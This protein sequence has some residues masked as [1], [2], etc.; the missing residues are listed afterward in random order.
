MVWCV[1]V[2]TTA[3]SGQQSNW[4][5]DLY[6]NTHDPE[7]ALAPFE[8][9]H[10]VEHCKGSV[11]DLTVANRG[12]LNV[13][14]TDNAAWEIYLSAAIARR[15][16]ETVNQV[17]KRLP[18]CRLPA[19]DDA[20]AWSQILHPALVKTG[21]TTRASIDTCIHIALGHN[22]ISVW[23]NAEHS[24]IDAYASMF[25]SK[26]ALFGEA[27]TR[28]R[29]SAYIASQGIPRQFPTTP[30]DDM[31]KNVL[32]NMVKIAKDFNG[33]HRRCAYEYFG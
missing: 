27:K 3:C 7:Q 25:L 28:A 11:F 10:V 31:A 30:K 19:N 1:A 14:L 24:S 26:A 2:L 5:A 9:R 4:D 29:S 21:G 8:A 20:A 12:G 18:G 32:A 13:N 33:S 6:V 22:R 15:M 17:V 16:V 23:K